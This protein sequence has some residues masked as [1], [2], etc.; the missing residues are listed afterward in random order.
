[1]SVGFVDYPFAGFGG[2]L[3]TGYAIGFKPVCN[4]LHSMAGN[5]NLIGSLLKCDC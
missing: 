5:A 2:A 4:L 3:A 1:M